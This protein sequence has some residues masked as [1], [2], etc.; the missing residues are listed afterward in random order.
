VPFTSFTVFWRNGGTRPARP[1]ALP[2]IPSFLA[3][4]HASPLFLR[5]DPKVRKKHDFL[6][7]EKRKMVEKE[8][9]KKEEK[10]IFVSS[11]CLLS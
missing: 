6:Q 2:C 7:K 9:K 5:T 1:V 8:E 4:H 11:R 10:N 3:R